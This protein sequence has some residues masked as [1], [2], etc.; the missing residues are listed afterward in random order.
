[1]TYAGWVRRSSRAPISRPCWPRP[2]LAGRHSGGHGAH[3]PSSSQ[4]AVAAAVS[5]SHR[6]IPAAYCAVKV[7][8]D[9]ALTFL[10]DLSQRSQS[11]VGLPEL[12][13]KCIALLHAEFGLFFASL[14]DDGTALRSEPPG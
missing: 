1:M 13:V 14:T 11:P 4:R 8:A 2:A 6:T 5:L 9:A 7:D 3:Q 10:R 12:L